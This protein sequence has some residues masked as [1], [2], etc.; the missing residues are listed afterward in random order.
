MKKTLAAV[1]VGTVMAALSVI[2]AQAAANDGVIGNSAKSDRYLVVCKDWSGTA[3]DPGCKAGTPKVSL[4]PGQNSK[5]VAGWAD[6][7]GFYVPNG[8]VAGGYK[9]PK[10]VKVSGL[11]GTKFTV[12]LVC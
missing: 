7:D 4:A 8:C 10:E 11:F 12:T 3:K 6:T 5:S 1:S 2:P 9:G